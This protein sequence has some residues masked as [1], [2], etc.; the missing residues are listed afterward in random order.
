ML[1]IRLQFN[2]GFVVKVRNTFKVMIRIRL[3]LG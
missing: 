1:G 2:L 3:G